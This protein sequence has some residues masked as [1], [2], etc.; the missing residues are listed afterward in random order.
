MSAFG[1]IIDLAAYLAISPPEFLFVDQAAGRVYLAKPADVGTRLAELPLAGAASGTSAD[2]GAARIVSPVDLSRRNFWGAAWSDV[3]GRTIVRTDESG[4]ERI[5]LYTVEP[6]GHFERLTDIGYLYGWSLSPDGRHLA[7]AEREGAEYSSGSI[8]L[9]ELPSKQER[10][11]FRDSPDLRPFWSRPAWR[12]DG[13]GFLVTLVAGEDRANQNIGLVQLSGPAASGPVL[14][15]DRAV[16]REL[17]LPESPWL[18]TKRFIYI[19]TESGSHE[20]Y[21]G[22]VGKPAQLIT[23]RRGP[24]PVAFPAGSHLAEA[25]V[26]FAAGRPL[27]ALVYRSPLEDL[28]RVLDPATGEVLY[29][30]AKAE[31]LT[32]AS[33]IG[34]TVILRASSPAEPPQLMKLH[35]DGASFALE[36]LAAFRAVQDELVQCKVE[37]VSYRTFDGLSAPGESGTL[38]AWLYTPVRPLP[39]TQATL[40]VEAFYG[41]GR[42]FHGIYQLPVP[43]VYCAAG[44]HFLSP[45]P[46]GSWTMGVAF[47]EFIRGDLGG[48]E[49]LDVVEAGRWAERTLGIPARRIGA[50]GLS[51]GG[52]ATMRLLTLPDSV[53]G[54]PVDF[55]YG[56]GIS[57]AGISNLLRH[58]S[59]SN[60]RGW[61]VDLMGD[62]PEKD[63]GKWLDRS[64]E[65]HA[66]RLQAPLLLLHGS[67]DIR[68]NPIESRA[69]A[70][71]LEELGK[72]VTYV[73]IDGAGHGTMP[74]EALQRYWR[75]IFAFIED[76]AKP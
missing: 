65:M 72:P 74:T 18:D 44:I 73:E 7:Y 29:E 57:D 68:V 67:N 69:M 64:P 17:V 35:P 27:A 55:R 8:R 56:F 5:N 41:G 19:S 2:L 10:I 15:T 53:N 76:V 52:Y 36:R 1:R 20:L 62:V 34:D 32:I 11:L 58:A 45:A 13:Q 30:E 70:A 59:N 23:A 24:S 42:S 26:F 61:S 33:A 63:P 12:P 48:N 46:R 47:R 3:L 43:Q 66:E 38:H 54:T 75:A 4:E 60:I 22:E 6:D 28:L 31:E 21:L 49:I 51:H 40:V 16:S 50:F 14:L 9:I 37:K 71:K 25:I 39:A